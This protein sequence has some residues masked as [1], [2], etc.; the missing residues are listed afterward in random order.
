[1]KKIV[2][3]GALAVALVA[4]G[5]A[6]CARIFE[7]E[8]RDGV[9]HG[10]VVV[11]G[12]LEGK[13]VLASWGW[14]DAAHTVPMTSR[15]V[16]DM[17]SVTKTAAGV[18][19]YL[20]AHARGKIPDFDVPFTNCLPAY[21]A[22]LARRVTLRDLANHVSGFGEAD[23]R[24]RRVYFSEDPRTML[25]NILSMP[26][27][28]PRPGRVFYSCRNYVLLGQAFESATGCRAAEF[29][30]KEIFLPAGMNDTSLGA[31]LPSIGPDRLAQ[32]FGTQKGGVISDFVARPLWAADIGTFNAGL[33]ST[34]EDMAK[35]MRV[36]LRGGVCDDGTRL[37]GEAE[38]ALIA[39]SPTN[40]VEGARTFG[41]QSASENLPP[42][43]F[44]TSL[45]H[46][47]W[48]GQTVLF[49]LKR[50]RYAIVITTRCGAYKRAKRERFDAI[51]ILMREGPKSERK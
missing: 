48:S 43:L 45:F 12:G 41:W 39:P 35:L 24:G 44:G 22:P 14:A 31:P 15:T 19:A 2:C 11:A 17:A 9:I 21:S 30:R 26:P 37:F 36:Y 23:G 50:R 10:A 18:T 29:C 34:A 40:R 5:A 20:V 49:D 3:L 28:A 25:Q 32:T 42:E 38:M 6:D 1:M 33:F 16:I 51:G 46:S 47:G 13:D 8:I 7:A 27:K 4:A